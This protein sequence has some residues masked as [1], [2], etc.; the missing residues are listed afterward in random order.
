MTVVGPEGLK[1]RLV[2][3]TAFMGQMPY[4]RAIEPSD[5]KTEHQEFGFNAYFLDSLKASS[6]PNNVEDQ[7]EY[8]FGDLSEDQ[9]AKMKDFLTKQN[10]QIQS[11][12]DKQPKQVLFPHGDGVMFKDDNLS[13]YPIEVRNKDGK[14]CYSYVCEPKQGNRKFLPKKAKEIQGL[15]PRDHYRLLTAGE[16]VTLEDGRVITPEMVCEPPAPA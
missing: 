8:L 10:T 5:A 4:L 1:E 15:V 7:D 9:I 14:V 16:S 11:E 6:C 2:N 12:L 13:V 3:A